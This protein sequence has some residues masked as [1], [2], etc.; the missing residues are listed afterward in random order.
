MQTQVNV[1]IYGQVIA[2]LCRNRKL[3]LYFIGTYNYT[4]QRTDISS[5]KCP[6]IN[7]LTFVL[8]KIIKLTLIITKFYKHYT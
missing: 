7:I 2:K 5:I 6:Q 8:Y 4:G 3:Y 1:L